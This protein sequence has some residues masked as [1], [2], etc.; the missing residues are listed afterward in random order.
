MQIKIT[1]QCKVQLCSVETPGATFIVV[2]HKG[3]DWKC[4]LSYLSTV[5]T[6]RKTRTLHKRIYNPVCPGSRE[7]SEERQGK[8][9]WI[10]CLF[11][12]PHQLTHWGYHSRTYT[13]MKTSPFR[14][15]PASFSEDTENPWQRSWCGGGGG[16]GILC[17]GYT[18]SMGSEDSL[19][20]NP[21]VLLM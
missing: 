6:H 10:Y 12:P 14:V 19:L 5:N 11:P 4:T 3:P 13:G 8:T 18:H 17:Q 21:L 20:S 16:F 7:R 2:S 15:I 9:Q 1:P